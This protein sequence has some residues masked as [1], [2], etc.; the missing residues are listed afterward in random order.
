MIGEKYMDSDHYY[1]GQDGGDNETMHTGFNNDVNRCSYDLPLQ[2]RKGLGNTLR[3]GSAHAS[4]INMAYCDGSVRV[5]SYE[6]DITVH[7]LAGNRFE[8]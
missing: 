2:D 7:Q 4:G 6:V 5:V 3:W 8:P 1:T